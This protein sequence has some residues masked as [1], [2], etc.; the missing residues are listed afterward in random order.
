MMCVWCVSHKGSH[1]EDLVPVAGPILEALETSGERDC[2]EGGLEVCFQGPFLTP[3]LYLPPKSLLPWCC[4]F[5]Q[6]QSNGANW[7]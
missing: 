6:T 3:S 2:Q 7:S 1:I 5:L 4:P